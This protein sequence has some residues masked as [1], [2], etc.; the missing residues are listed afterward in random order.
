MDLTNFDT[1]FEKQTKVKQHFLMPEHPYRLLMIGPSGCGKSNL[2]LNMLTKYLYYDRIYIICKDA[3]EDKY[4]F[5]IEFFKELEKEKGYQMLYMSTT[6]N[7]L[8]DPDSFDKSEVNLIIF[9]D[10]VVERDQKVIEDLFIRGRKRNASLIYLSQSYFDIPK[11]IRLNC[12]YVILFNLGNKRELTELH[13][14]YATRIDK[15]EFM[16][17]YREATNT[18]YSFLMI[19]NKTQ[20]LCQS[21]RKGFDGFYC[22]SQKK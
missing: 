13:K 9:D 2:L 17:L 22:P 4:Q 1:L 15:D 20:H 19:D 14:V 5:L 3:E 8:P 12:N 10:M 18:P 7:D 21:F 11:T 6:L 16:K